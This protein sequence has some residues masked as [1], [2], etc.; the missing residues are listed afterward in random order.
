MKAP[1]EISL[2]EVKESAYYAHGESWRRHVVLA[3]SYVDFHLSE[4]ISLASESRDDAV[5]AFNDYVFD[6]S[7]IDYER[8]LMTIRNIPCE[9]IKEA[10]ENCMMTEDEAVMILATV[11]EQCFLNIVQNGAGESRCFIELCFGGNE[12]PIGLEFCSGTFTA[13]AYISDAMQ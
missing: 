4:C 6:S 13:R 9:N 5:S 2:E 7:R 8:I 10:L 11:Q 12:F 1:S 3:S